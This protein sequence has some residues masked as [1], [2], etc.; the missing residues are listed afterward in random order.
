MRKSIIVSH[1]NSLQFL[2]LMVEVEN[3]F[4]F[5]IY[6]KSNEL[7]KNISVNRIE[8][9]C[10]NVGREGSCYIQHIINNYDNLNDINIFIQDDF[11]NHLFNI[12]YFLENFENNKNKEFYQFP[13]ASRSVDYPFVIRRAVV[14]GVVNFGFG[15]SDGVF[16]LSRY[17]SIPLP[18]IYETE[19]CANFFVSRNRLHRYSKEK[20]IQIL[21]WL[22]K[23]PMNEWVLEHSWKMLFM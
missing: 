18:E 9:K 15:D 12:G 10:D 21:N 20:Y 3:E 8:I 19:V 6:N 2:D 11:Y 14:N 16:H 7:L 22:Q 23:D 5:I 4:N 1:Y 13:C 17:L